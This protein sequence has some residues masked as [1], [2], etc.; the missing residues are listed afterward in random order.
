MIVIVIMLTRCGNIYMNSAR[1]EGT[2][3]LDPLSIYTY[4]KLFYAIYTNAQNGSR[5]NEVLGPGLI[6]MSHSDH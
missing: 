4:E 5:L 1:E 6:L 2:R 3:G